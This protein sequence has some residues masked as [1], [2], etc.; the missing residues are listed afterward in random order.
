M[1]DKLDEARSRAAA[2]MQ[3]LQAKNGQAA[4]AALGEAIE[5]GWPG[6]DV[7]IALSF[8]HSLLGDMERMDLAKQLLSEL[9]GVMS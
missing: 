9:P 7:W 6:P 3:A 5:L 8:A 2:G 1:S 4:R